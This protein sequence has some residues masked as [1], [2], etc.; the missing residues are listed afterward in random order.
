[1]KPLLVFHANFRK[2]SGPLVSGETQITFDV[3]ELFENETEGIIR[4]TKNKNLLVV[5]YD[6][7]DYVGKI[8]SPDNQQNQ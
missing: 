4:K 2:I 1:M 6:V 5:V 8:N 3:P 7:D